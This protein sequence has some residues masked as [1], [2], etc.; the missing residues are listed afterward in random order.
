MSKVWTRFETEAHGL[1]NRPISI[2]KQYITED[3]V[4]QMDKDFSDKDYNRGP[5][6]L[7]LRRYG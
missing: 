4:L 6:P 7:H 5:R 3:N 2:Y 1:L